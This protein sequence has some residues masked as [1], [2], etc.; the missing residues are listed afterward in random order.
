LK[1]AE[2]AKADYN[3]AGANPGRPAEEPKDN[4][5]GQK[6]EYASKREVDLRLENRALGRSCFGDKYY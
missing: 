3:K 4:T 5:C 6:L 1:D 2:E